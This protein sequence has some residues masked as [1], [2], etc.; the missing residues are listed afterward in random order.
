[1]IHQHQLA[2]AIIIFIGS[3]IA[4]AL[5][6]AALNSPFNDIMSTAGSV[7]TSAEAQAGQNII[8]QAWLIAPFGVVVLGLIQLIGAAAK[9]S[10]L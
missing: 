10:K 7:G 4:A 1:M 8:Q 6:I 2:N 9:E 3:L 5:I